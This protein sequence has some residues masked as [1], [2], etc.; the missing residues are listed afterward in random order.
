MQ[1]RDVNP[2]D[3]VAP[4]GQTRKGWWWRAPSR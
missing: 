2:W 4:L 1:R 3:W